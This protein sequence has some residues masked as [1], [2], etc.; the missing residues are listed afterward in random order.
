M[1]MLCIPMPFLLPTLL[2]L[3]ALFAFAVAAAVAL[4]PTPAAM[5]DALIILL[6]L[7][8]IPINECG[9]L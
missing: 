4:F 8:D 9:L 3:A 2:A 5:E 7:G 6:S 1:P